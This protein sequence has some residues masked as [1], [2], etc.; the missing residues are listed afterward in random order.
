[1]PG[2]LAHD[3]AADGRLIEAVRRD[4]TG[5]DGHATATA[6]RVIWTA[7]HIDA[8]RRLHTGILGPAREAAAVWSSRR[9]W[10]TPRRPRPVRSDASVG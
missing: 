6:V 4:L 9:A 1:V 5:E 8:A 10:R 7:D 2:P 3:K